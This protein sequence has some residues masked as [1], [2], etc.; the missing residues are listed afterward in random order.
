MF[1]PA[2]LASKGRHGSG[3]INRRALNPLKVSRASAS[4][5]PQTAASISPSM[6]SSAACPM[7]MALDEQAA[8]M[9]ARAPVS[10]KW[11]AMASTGAFEK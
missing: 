9:H 10:S 8:T 7:A 4:V 5:P 6:M 1:M 11:L 3:S 2:R